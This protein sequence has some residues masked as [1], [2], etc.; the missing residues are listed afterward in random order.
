MVMELVDMKYGTVDKAFER[1]NPVESSYS[2]QGGSIT[3]AGSIHGG[4]LMVRYI[5]VSRR[6]SRSREHSVTIW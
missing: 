4:S 1:E 6:E 2:L 5:K 3:P